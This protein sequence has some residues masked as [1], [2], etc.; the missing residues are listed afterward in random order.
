MPS[1][2]PVGRSVKTLSGHVSPDNDVI[3]T[4][5]NPFSTSGGLAVLHGNL[6]PHSAVTKPA[7]IR[8]DMLV[9]SGPARVFDSEAQAN[10]AIMADAVQTR[11]RGGDP[12]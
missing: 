1:P 7:A 3:K 12:L 5:D 2:L 8:N 4:V 6:A 9:F 10:A 11:R